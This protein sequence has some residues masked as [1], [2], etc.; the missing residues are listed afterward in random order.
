MRYAD[1]SCPFS[2]VVA[3]LSVCDEH[4]DAIKALG[5]SLKT[6]ADNLETSLNQ[7]GA[8][9]PARLQAGAGSVSNATALACAPI[10]TGV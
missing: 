9:P 1:H 8:P 2:T 3:A 7:I 5:Q 10:R 4:A 6:C